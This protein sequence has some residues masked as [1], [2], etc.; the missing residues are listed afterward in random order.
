MG[1]GEK[2]ATLIAGFLEEKVGEMRDKQYLKT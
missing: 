1:H 2:S